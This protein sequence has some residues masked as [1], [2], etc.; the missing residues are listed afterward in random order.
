M[1]KKLFISIFNSIDPNDGKAIVLD[2]SNTLEEAKNVVRND[3]EAY[4]DACAGMDLVAD[5]DEM[6]I[7]TED[8]SIICE[9]NISEHDFEIDES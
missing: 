6:C 2:V 1:T 4:L 5:F 8:Y 7:H 9:W 3:M